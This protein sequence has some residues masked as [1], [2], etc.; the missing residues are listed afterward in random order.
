MTFSNPLNKNKEIVYTYYLLPKNEIT[1]GT[2]VA[3][4]NVKLNKKYHM[5]LEIF[6][7]ENRTNLISK[8]NQI[9]ISPVDNTNGCIEVNKELKKEKYGYLVDGSKI[10]SLEH[11][12]IECNKQPITNSNINVKNSKYWKENLHTYYQIPKNWFVEKRFEN[13]ASSLYITKDKFDKNEQFKIG[14][15]LHYIK[16]CKNNK[17]QNPDNLTPSLYAKNQVI[18]L[19]YYIKRTI[20]QKPYTFKDNHLLGYGVT[21]KDDKYTMRNIA[22][23]DDINNVC[24]NMMFEAPNK[25]WKSVENI[26]NEIIESHWKK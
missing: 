19:S 10:L 12:I 11:L 21:T 25:D 17:I 24:L 23:G 8:I 13:D 9:I 5:I 20:V 14:F 6:S 3:L 22:L 18:N 1:N 16:N 26:G 4:S 7:D 2:H 15:S